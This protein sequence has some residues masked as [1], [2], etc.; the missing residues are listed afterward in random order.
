MSQW[1]RLPLPSVIFQSCPQFLLVGDIHRHNLHR[2]NIP[3]GY[4]N[5]T[6]DEKTA[7]SIFMLLL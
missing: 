4:P 2:R 6:A 7:V 5:P 3:I 1:F